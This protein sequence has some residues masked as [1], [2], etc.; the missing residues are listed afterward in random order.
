M[1]T[2]LSIHLKVDFINMAKRADYKM[3]NFTRNLEFVNKRDFRNEKC[4]IPP[5]IINTILIMR[6]LTGKYQLRHCTSYL[7]RTSHICQGHQKQGKSGKHSQEEPKK[8]W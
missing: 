1:I 7:I 3:H 4:S 6:K 5:K 2:T 8:S